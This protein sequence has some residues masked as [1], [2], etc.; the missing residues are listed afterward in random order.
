M[1]P[2]CVKAQM[3]LEMLAYISLAGISLLYS[4]RAIGT[5]Y[6]GFNQSIIGYE[7]ATFSEQVNSAIL[8]NYSSLS[9]YVPYGFCPNGIN[10]SEVGTKYGKVYFSE[11][12]RESGDKI[13]GPG[14]ERINLSYDYG[15]VE[16]G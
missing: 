14:T 5:F 1:V 9:T 2:D 11:Y 8:D 13:C 3:S 6:S 7:Y 12:V 16:V 10:G 15:Y 4:A